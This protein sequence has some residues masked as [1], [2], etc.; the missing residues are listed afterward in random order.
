NAY[1]EFTQQGR[2]CV[3]IGT[4]STGQGHE[5]SY[6]Q[7]VAARLG[8]GIESIDFIQGDTD[9]VPTG[10]GT[11]GSRSMAIGG[12][13][14]CL[15]TD[16]VVDAGRRMAA[17]LMEAAEIDI[18]FEQGAFRIAGTDRSLPLVEVALASFDDSKRPDGVQPG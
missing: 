1:V 7:M 11:A 14:I 17:E 5:T 2:V 13:A 9:R 10:E 4:Q 16:R 6:G 8:V 18:E 15:T 3:R 12:S